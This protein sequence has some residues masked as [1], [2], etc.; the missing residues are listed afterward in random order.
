MAIVWPA[1]SIDAPDAGPQSFLDVVDGR[2]SPGPRALQGVVQPVTEKVKEGSGVTSP[3]SLFFWNARRRGWRLAA[4]SYSAKRARPRRLR[5]PWGFAGRR[6]WPDVLSAGEVAVNL[7][8]KSLAHLPR[9][10]RKLRSA[11][12]L[13]IRGVTR[14]RAIRGQRVTASRSA[15]RRRTAW[16]NCCGVSQR[17]KLG[18]RGNS[19]DRQGVFSARLL[20]PDRAGGVE[21]SCARAGLSAATPMSL[22]ARANGWYCRAT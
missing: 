7:R 21:A 18:R 11:S 15:S 8:L 19:A 2:K 10:S 22:C 17:W 16:P 4:E 5:A 3:V 20:L 12:W 6:H 9:V 14:T 1:P 13:P